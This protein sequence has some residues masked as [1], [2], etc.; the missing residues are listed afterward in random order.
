MTEVLQILDAT[1]GEPIPNPMDMA[2]RQDQPDS[3]CR[4]IASS[5]GA[6]DLKLQSKPSALPST[7]AKDR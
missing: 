5:S 6:M 2:I 7:T 4:R 3:A 1:S